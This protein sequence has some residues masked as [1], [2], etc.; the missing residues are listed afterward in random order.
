VTEY[1]LSQDRS[2]CII[3]IVLATTANNMNFGWLLQ[4]TTRDCRVFNILKVVPGR[5]SREDSKPVSSYGI[6]GTEKS[7]KLNSMALC[8][9]SKHRENSS[10]ANRITQ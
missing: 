9:S 4:V 7:V 8:M 5:F 6:P 1:K 2:T 3:H 10:R